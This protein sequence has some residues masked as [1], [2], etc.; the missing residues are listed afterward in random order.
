MNGTYFVWQVLRITLAL[1]ISYGILSFLL[2]ATNSSSQTRVIVWM[3]SLVQCWMLVSF[4][5]EVPWY[6]PTVSVTGPVVAAAEGL[7]WEPNMPRDPTTASLPEA[8]SV[9]WWPVLLAAMVAVWLGGISFLVVK[10]VREFRR[11]RKAVSLFPRVAGS[12][13]DQAGLWISELR[14]VTQELKID[15]PIDFRFSEDV[16]PLVCRVNGSYVVLTPVE[17]WQRASRHD[18]VAILRH[19]L[20]HIRRRDPWLMLCARILVLPQWFNPASWLALR[21][22]DE[23]IEM[24]CDDDVL[25]LPQACKLEYAKAIVSLL[26]FKNRHLQ[27]SLAADGPPVQ[28][29]I[30]RIVQPKGAEMKFARMLGLLSLFVI[31]LFCLFRMELVTQE[32]SVV[33]AKAETSVRLSERP[34]KSVRVN[35]EEGEHEA[36]WRRYR[37]RSYYV[38]DLILSEANQK[39]QKE[40]GMLGGITAA[41]F[42]PLIELIE[43]AV[44]SDS[45]DDNGKGGEARIAPY[46]KHLCLVISHDPEAHGQIVEI[47]GQLRELNSTTLTLDALFVL[48]PRTSKIGDDIPASGSVISEKAVK[49]IRRETAKLASGNLLS[50]PKV[51]LYSGQYATYEVPEDWKMKNVRVTAVKVM[52]KKEPTFE[53]FCSEA[54]PKTF[55]GPAPVAAKVLPIVDGKTARHAGPLKTRKDSSIACFDLSEFLIDANPKYRAI[56]VIDTKILKRELD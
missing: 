43:G 3:L 33:V 31:S 17:Y 54:P 21:R 8:V 5:V 24:A 44:E 29:R 9:D 50:K 37:N 51:T 42:Q 2:N 28:Q 4:V 48:V 13:L 14:T 11:L 20:A 56:M 27:F 34:T 26:E 47:L 41:D 52:K 22:L 53:L 10:Y 39:L 36:V 46:V 18:R 15:V 32:P 16:G 6:E 40:K 1:S 7:S 55:S 38:G 23:S 25:A 19:E 45:W 35:Q 49:E 30:Q 12:N